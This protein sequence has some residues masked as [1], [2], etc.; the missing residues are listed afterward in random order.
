M[1]NKEKAEENTIEIKPNRV[2]DKYVVM[3]KEDYLTL[4]SELMDM[5]CK[6][7]S[8]KCNKCS[9]Y[10]LLTKYGVPRFDGNKKKKNC[11][12]SY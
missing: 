9:V 7:C 2:K 11:K 3:S 6:G 10:E 4:L 12:Y 5:N 8:K 1:T